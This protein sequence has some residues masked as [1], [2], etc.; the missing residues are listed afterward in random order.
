MDEHALHVYELTQIIINQKSKTMKSELIFCP[1]CE[2]KELGERVDEVL[3]D[4]QL[5]DWDT[6]YEHVDD[7]G[8]IKVCFDCQ[9][10]DDAD[11][12]AKGEG[13]D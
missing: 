9:E 5:Q 7:D 11:D 13:W 3:R 4:Q 10:W 8:E 2:S 12:D 1:T 6:A